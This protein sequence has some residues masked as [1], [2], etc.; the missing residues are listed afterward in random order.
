MH[1][2]NLPFGKE[3]IKLELPEEQVSGVLVSHAHE[4]KAPKSEAEL[5][6]DALA[7]PIGSPKLSDLAKGKKNC[8]IISSDHTRPVPSH[9]IMPQL[10]AELR[11]GNPDIDITILIATG[12][13]R[14]T[15]KEELIAK[16]GKEIAE[17]EKFVIHVSRNDEDMVSVG[18]LPSGGDCRINKVAANADLLISEGFIEPHFFAGMS[19]GR[20]S[21]LPGIASKVTVLANHCSEFINSPHARTGILQGNPIHEDMLYAAKAAKLAFICNVVIDADKKVIA[22]FAGDR[23][24]AHY[25]GADFEMKLAGVKPVPAD[26]VITTNGGYP[27]DQNIYQSVKGMTAAEAT[28]KEGGVIIDVSSCSDGHGGEDFYNNLKNAESIQKA[29]DEIL[30]RGRNETVFDQW[31]A[32]ILMRMLLKF[33]IIMVTEAPQQ[34][35]EDMHMKYVASVDDALAMAKEVLA[36][37]GITDPKITVIPDGVSV[38]VK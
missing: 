14:A 4:Y 35:V 38:I 3:K 13:H 24:K 19:G 12:M 8:V 15:T 25:A 7:N 9:V 20:K 17:H 30:A 28:C 37:K 16:Y 18:T 21:V 22:A 32:Q 1:T 34:M 33:T 31:E 5:V 27:L 29:M 2:F 11:K 23:E 36:K 10:L 26:I 6:A